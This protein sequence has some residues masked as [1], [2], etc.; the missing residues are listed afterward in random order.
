MSAGLKWPT[1]EMA[2]EGTGNCSITSPV[3]SSVVLLRTMVKVRGAA[4]RGRPCAKAIRP[5]WSS[6]GF[7]L[8]RVG[9][10][11]WG[12]SRIGR[13]VWMEVGVAQKTSRARPTFIAQKASW[14]YPA[15]TLPLPFSPSSSP[16]SHLRPAGPR[17]TCPPRP[18][19]DQTRPPWSWP[20]ACHTPSCSKYWFRAK[21][22]SCE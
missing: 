21:A 5:P 8:S 9:S 19:S 16:S 10:Y 11:T 12:S 6:K 22:P 1:T 17:V 14:V 7:L 13:A 4:S 18:T 20:S 2:D 3:Q 15:K